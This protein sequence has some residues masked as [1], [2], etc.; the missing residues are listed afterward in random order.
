MAAVKL[1]PRL[2]Q[3]RRGG[4][5]GWL[6][7]LHSFASNQYN[8]G[9][10]HNKWG[11]LR[12]L[13]EDRVEPHTGF[14]LHGH[15]EFQIFSYVVSG[16]LEHHDSM[17]NIEI[18]KRGDIQMTQAGTG[19]RHS[20]AAHGPKQA[21]FLQIWVEPTKTG[22]QPRYFTRHFSDEEKKDKWVRIVAPVT[23]EGVKAE[24][25]AVGPTPIHSNL[26][27]YATLLSPQSSLGYTLPPL[28]GQKLRKA[29]VHLVQ[30][31]GYN[32]GPGTGAHVRVSGEGAIAEIREGDAV[33]IEAPAGEEI[34]LE[35]VG[36]LT[37]E[38]LLFDVGESQLKL[39]ADDDGDDDI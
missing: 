27:A 26:T 2:S 37:A 12:V 31:S 29:Y 18:L 36:E 11:A 22:L 9:Y 13:N 38:L 7:G 23:S 39:F 1:T 4:N 14:G 25:E 35:N 28:E 34:K 16:E 21:H 8:P 10:K 19:I 33:Y 20:E 17:S 30:M 32:P 15:S 5:I 6:K 24:R 3:D